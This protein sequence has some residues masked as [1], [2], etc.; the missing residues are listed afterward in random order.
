M[1]LFIGHAKINFY[2][3]IKIKLLEYI[4]VSGSSLQLDE[5]LKVIGLSE[6]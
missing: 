4:C 6:F 2:Q 1:K 5:M 3:R